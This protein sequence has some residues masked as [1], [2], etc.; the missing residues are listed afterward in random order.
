MFEPEQ[1]AELVAARFPFPALDVPEDP[2][3]QIEC[4]LANAGTR[5]NGNEPARHAGVE[6]VRGMQITVQQNDLLGRRG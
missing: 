6:H 2:V 5:V 3:H 1:G 4:G